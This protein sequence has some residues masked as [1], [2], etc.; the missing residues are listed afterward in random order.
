MCKVSVLSRM[1]QTIWDIVELRSNRTWAG[2]EMEIDEFHD[3]K[4]L[5]S[6]FY[7]TDTIV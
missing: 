3:T 5:I 1:S 4:I 6:S 2:Q 7:L